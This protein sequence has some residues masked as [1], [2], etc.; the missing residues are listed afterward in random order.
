ML[1]TKIKQPLPESGRYRLMLM[2]L[3]GANI[4]AVIISFGVGHYLVPIKTVIE[5]VGARLGLYHGEIAPQVLTVI[6]KVRLPRILSAML[7]GMALAASGSAYQGMFHNPL[8]SPDILGVTAGAGLGAAISISAGL[9]Y[10][11]TQLLAFAGG[12]ITVGLACL[13]SSRSRYSITLS[14]VLTGA[15]LKALCEAGTSLL[16]Y[17][18]DPN[19]TLPAITYWLMGSLAKTNMKG[20]LFSLPF[21]LLGFA[22][23]FLCRWR[24]NLLS[25]NDEESQ[26][27]GIH[28]GRNRMI[29]IFGATMLSAAAVCLGGQIGWI[30]LMIPHFTRIIFGADYRRLIP[31]CALSG[32]LFLL[33]IDNLARTLLTIEIPVGVLTAFFGVPFFLMLILRKDDQK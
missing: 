19:D 28:P 7:I 31:A 14:L 4:A 8:V 13:V 20:L 22:I 10:Y 5:T 23:L 9:P 21:M 6:W 26:S 18:A 11:M 1:H 12:I 27:L 30:G 3:I 29:V 16:K 25:L 15:M 24:L 33:I 2:L 17:A 32:S